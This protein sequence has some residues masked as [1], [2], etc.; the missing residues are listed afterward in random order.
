MSISALNGTGLQTT[1]P[2]NYPSQSGGG[3]TPSGAPASSA[4]SIPG[5]TPPVSGASAA[6]NLSAETVTKAAA[7]V[8]K[9]INSQAGGTQT[10]LTVDKSSGLDVVKVLDTTNNNTEITQYPSKEIVALAQAIETLQGL[11]STI[12]ILHNSTA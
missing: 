9:F 4:A 12:G 8:E 2:I 6:A 1:A 5:A 10:Q 11:T 3:V 7:T